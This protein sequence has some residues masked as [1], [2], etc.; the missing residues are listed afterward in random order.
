MPSPPNL[1]NT[2]KLV[3]Q[4]TKV[5]LVTVKTREGKIAPLVG[6]TIYMTVRDGVGGTVL[7]TKTSGDGIE[8]TCPELG[9]ATIT[10]TTEDTDIATGCYRYDIWVE[11][12]TDPPT[13]H[14][15]V[16]NAEL[17]VEAAIT[18]FTP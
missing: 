14:P 13:R 4:Q 1:L 18:D 16:K 11:Y 2:V 12:P 7:I 8:V 15:V 6:A 17:I 5:L 10:L 9:Q 3:Q